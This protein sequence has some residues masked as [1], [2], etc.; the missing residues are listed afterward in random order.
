MTNNIIKTIK[1]GEVAPLKAMCE[2][3]LTLA[4]DILN[5]TELSKEDKAEV[6]LS[7]VAKGQKAL[8]FKPSKFSH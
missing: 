5:A 3:P 6:N 1:E 7:K 4:Q 2:K 8:S